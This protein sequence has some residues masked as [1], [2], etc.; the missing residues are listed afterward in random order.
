MSE[1]VGAYTAPNKLVKELKSSSSVPNALLGLNRW[2]KP[3]DLAGTG[4]TS[5]LKL[6]RIDVIPAARRLSDDSVV[7]R[8]PLSGQDIEQFIALS[9]FEHFFH[10]EFRSDVFSIK[11]PS[12]TDKSC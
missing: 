9:P 5:G 6:K 7:S 4:I 10:R 2:D 3:N 11:R 1:F 8:K 12:T